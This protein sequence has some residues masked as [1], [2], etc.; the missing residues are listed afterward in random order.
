MTVAERFDH[1][2]LV[3]SLCSLGAMMIIALCGLVMGSDAQW[4]ENSR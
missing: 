3:V 4:N 1:I 2:I